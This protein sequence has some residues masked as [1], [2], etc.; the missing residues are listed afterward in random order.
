MATVV[1]WEAN[2][3][4]YTVVCF[5][6]GCHFPTFRCCRIFVC[7]CL[8][9]AFFFSLASF[10]DWSDLSPLHDKL[11]HHHSSFTVKEFICTY[12]RS[13][14]TVHVS[15][16]IPFITLLKVVGPNLRI[17]V[18]NKTCKLA[19]LSC[20]RSYPPLWKFK[21]RCGHNHRRCTIS[22]TTR[23]DCSLQIASSLPSSTNL[24]RVI[25]EPKH[26]SSRE[27]GKSVHESSFSRVLFIHCR[28]LRLRQ[29]DQKNSLRPLPRVEDLRL[30][31]SVT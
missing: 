23:S 14:R 29:L 9:P 31:K 22:P 13:E 19:R 21:I 24:T 6:C 16:R 2:A 30:Q 7:F 15:D 10:P 25:A 5:L 3:E 12:P 4:L 8:S 26:K 17:K 28:R 27:C 20:I 1:H 11:F 18:A